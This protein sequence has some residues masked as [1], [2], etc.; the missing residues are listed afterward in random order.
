M[1]ALPKRTSPTDEQAAK[2]RSTR[3]LEAGDSADVPA[4]IISGDHHSDPVWILNAGEQIVEGV[5]EYVL[6]H[7]EGH[8]ST[9]YRAPVGRLFSVG[10]HGV[11]HRGGAV[12][13]RAESAGLVDRPCCGNTSAV[14]R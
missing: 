5:V 3:R 1:T 4:L 8:L 14:V 13:C 7:R 10:V 6:D 9:V 11:F 2:L 12:K